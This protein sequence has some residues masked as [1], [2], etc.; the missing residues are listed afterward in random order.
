MKSMR[1]PLTTLGFL[2]SFQVGLFHQLAG[3]LKDDPSSSVDGPLCTLGVAVED[4]G[5]D[6][7]SQPLLR[8]A[9]LVAVVHSQEE[10]SETSPGTGVAGG[11]AAV[12]LV[13]SACIGLLVA[14]LTMEENDD[15]S[16]DCSI[17]ADEK[18]VDVFAGPD[19]VGWCGH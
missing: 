5:G 18:C 6:G 8:V 19:F 1:V 17:A 2:R 9:D 10:T 13:I 7:V 3:V 15:A 4:A 11:E 16:L 14:G 12:V